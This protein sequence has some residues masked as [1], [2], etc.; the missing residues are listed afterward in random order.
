MKHTSK[1]VSKSAPELE[2]SRVPVHAALTN[3]L[4]DAAPDKANWALLLENIRQVSPSTRITLIRQGYSIEVVDLLSQ[5]LAMS[6]QQVLDV[7]G[8][9]RST[10]N[11]LRRTH[12]RLSSAISERI[13]RV[14]EFTAIAEDVLGSRKSAA[15]WLSDVNLALGNATPLSLLDTE[16]GTV[17]V[18]RA[19]NAITYGGGV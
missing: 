4:N 8:L 19:L 5:S 16:I 9:S 3:L 1:N 6:K 12:G 17:Q 11:R 14:S 18:R 15:A 7:F 13:D 10:A 2:S